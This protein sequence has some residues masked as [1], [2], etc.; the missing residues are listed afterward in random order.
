MTD[1]RVVVDAS[2]LVEFLGATNPDKALVRRLLTAVAAAPELIDIEILNTV[3]KHARH[4][5]IQQSAADGVVAD[6]LQ[7]P[8]AR[9]PH[10]ALVARIW[11]LRHAITCY[12]AAYVALAEALDVPLVTCDAKLAGSNGHRA[13]IE[14]YPR[15]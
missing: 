8:L 13:E 6:L 15:G 1:N 4:G 9:S 3:R 5:R 14:L 7:Y 12:D 11:Q 2:A 10:R